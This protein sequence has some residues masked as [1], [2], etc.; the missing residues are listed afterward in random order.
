M[1]RGP[2]HWHTVIR[3][4]PHRPPTRTG[5]LT[6]INELGNTTSASAVRTSG[7]TFDSGD[8]SAGPLNRVL[9]L[10]NRANLVYFQ[11][12]RKESE[13]PARVVVACRLTELSSGEHAVEGTHG[14]FY[15][16]SYYLSLLHRNGLTIIARFHSRDRQFML[17]P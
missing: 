7:V 16:P 10:I 12:R 15:S 8:R 9:D 1:C 11:K 5:H 6:V 2:P 14:Q 17:C 13:P 4:D 3:Y